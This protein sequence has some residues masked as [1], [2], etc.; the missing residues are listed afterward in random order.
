[1]AEFETSPRGDPHNWNSLDNYRFLHEKHLA[2]HPLVLR[3]GWTLE[4]EVTS[5]P[6]LP[7]D[8]IKLTGIVVCLNRLV[9]EITKE[10]DLDRTQT[11]RVR[12][13]R[14]RYNA[15]FPKGENVLRYD[16]M[17]S[18]EPDVYHRHVFDPDTGEQ[19]SFRTLTRAQFPVMH[20]VLDELLQ[21]F[22]PD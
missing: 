17:H 22:P 2:Q 11:H 19:I 1:M 18:D 13:S 3:E 20:E 9:L 14:F 7:Y 12:M 8:Y 6:L 10:G 5:R 16:N 21:M 4:I 15:H